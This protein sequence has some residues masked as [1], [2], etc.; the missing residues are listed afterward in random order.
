MATTLQCLSNIIKRK[1]VLRSNFL[2][3]TMKILH[4]CTLIF[5]FS[6]LN[7]HLQ[8][9]ALGVKDAVFQGYLLD[10]EMCISLRANGNFMFLYKVENILGQHKSYPDALEFFPLF[11]L[12]CVHQNSGNSVLIV[13]LQL[14]LRHFSFNIG[15]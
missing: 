10:M 14:S 4:L 13:L 3:H 6:V 15:H 11:I 5:P 7:D 9:L 8:E 12:S 1:D 2:C